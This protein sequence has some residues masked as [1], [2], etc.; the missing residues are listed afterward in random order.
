MSFNTQNMLIAAGAAG[1]FAV[2][3]KNIP[4]AVVVGVGSYYVVDKVVPDMNS[5]IEEE[6]LKQ[7][8]KYNYQNAVQY[9]NNTGDQ[10]PPAPKINL[11]PIKGVNPMFSPIFMY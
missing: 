7:L 8:D 1:L 3:T 5:Q 4:V 2:V 6:K 10:S 9:A 11:L